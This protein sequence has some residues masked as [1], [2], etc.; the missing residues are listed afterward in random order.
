MTVLFV[1]KERAPGERRVAATPDAVRRLAGDVEVVLEAGAGQQAGTSDDD[2]V[3]AGAKIHDGP[4]PPDGTDVVVRVAPPTLDEVGRLPEGVTL[5]SLIAPHRNQ[6]SVRALAQRR[7]TTVAMELVPRI[8]RAQAMDALSSQASIAG[9]RAVIVAAHE[10]AK[11][12]PLFMTAAGTIRPANVVVLGAGVAGLQAVATARRLGAVVYVSDIREAA[13][14]EVAS[15]GGK[16]IEVPDAE[17]L[18]GEGGYAKEAGDDFLARQR[19]VLT[20]HLSSAHAVITTAQIPGR[21]APEL[22]TAA[23]VEAMQ[24][25]S[26]VIDL[27]AADGGNCA[28]TDAGGV[29]E[30]QG[31]RIIPG[32]H[33]PSDMAPEASALYARNIAAFLGLL[34]DDHGALHLDLDDE[35]VAGAL[36]THDGEVTHPPTATLLGGDA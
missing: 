29:V 1:P 16:F 31:V 14:E 35:V 6:D 28:L 17:D 22:I 18:T 7:V 24:P 33:L 25:G 2:Y 20:E 13:R 34:L 19:A 12:F 27:A 9:Y 3:E 26:V 8:S 32:Q 30:H 11:L 36:L 21:K 23:M 5:L 10:A 4:A 15:L